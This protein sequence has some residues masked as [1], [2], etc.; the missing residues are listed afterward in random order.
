MTDTTG[1]RVVDYIIM[2]YISN[3][4][5]TDDMLDKLV[6]EMGCKC[7][8]KAYAISALKENGMIDSDEG[9]FFLTADGKRAMVEARKMV[10]ELSRH[11]KSNQLPVT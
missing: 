7:C 4:S 8:G 5:P 9:G 1:I 10:N 11:S 6:K 3:E 2:H